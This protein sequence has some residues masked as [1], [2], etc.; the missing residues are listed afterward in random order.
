MTDRNATPN[1]ATEANA[2]AMTILTQINRALLTIGNARCQ[3][4][5]IDLPPDVSP[6]HAR[7]IPE[8]CEHLEHA[9]GHLMEAQMNI[10]RDLTGENALDIEEPEEYLRRVYPT[11]QAYL[12]DMREQVGQLVGRFGSYKLPGELDR[13]RYGMFVEMH[14]INEKL[15]QMIEQLEPE[16]AEGEGEGGAG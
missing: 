3:V 16:T 8:V 10:I 13:E 15:C 6:S 9:S 4:A 5:A 1:P 12:E 11:H 14:D 7:Y 2:E